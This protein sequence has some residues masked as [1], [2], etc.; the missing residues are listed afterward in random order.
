[1]KYNNI[2]RRMRWLGIA[3][4]LCALGLS[5]S[6]CSSIVD[7]STTSKP[8]ENDA[9]MYYLKLDGSGNKYYYSI[10]QPS[11][12]KL[13]MIMEGDYQSKTYN[14]A[15]A[16]DCQWVFQQSNQ[17]EE[18]YFAVNSD[19]AFDLGSG[20]SWSDTSVWVDLKA[21]LSG[22]A[23]WSFDYHGDVVVASVKAY[24][25]SAKVGN[26]VYD[27]VIQVQ[28]TGKYNSGTKWFARGIGEIFE[29][30]SH[31]YGYEQRSL[32]SCQVMN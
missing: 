30:I 22:N 26:K 7:P 17:Q 14:Q 8:Q 10:Q 15:E 21:P 4:V 27:D 6:G 5:Y 13:T 1:M 9:R 2:T 32:D 18:W 29:S 3:S 12:D 28:Y 24:G 23:T 31:P 16:Y 25:A 20:V 11:T 19:A